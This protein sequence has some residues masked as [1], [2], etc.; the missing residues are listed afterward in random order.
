MNRIL[1][2]IGILLFAFCQNGGATTYVADSCSDTH[3]QAAIDLTSNG[4]TV[5]VPAGSCTWTTRVNITTGITLQ[6]AGVDVTT[7]TNDVPTSERCNDLQLL[8]VNTS[9]N[10]HITGFTITDTGSNYCYDGT[11]DVRG[12]ATGFR[13]NN[14]KFE[15]L[16]YRGI[17][18]S[19][20]TY[21]VIDNCTFNDITNQVIFMRSPAS[22]T[23][24]ALWTTDTTRGGVDQLFI[25][26]CT[27]NNTTP[28]K[29]VFDGDYGTK[30]VF[31]HNTVT[32]SWVL[33]HGHEMSPGALRF[34]VYDNT[35]TV[36]AAQN[37]AAITI[38]GGESLCFNNTIVGDYGNDL[39]V[40][41]TDCPVIYADYCSCTEAGTYPC[42]EKDH[43]CTDN[44]GEPCEGSIG[45]T[46]GVDIAHQSL[47][48]NY[49]WNNTDDGSTLDAVFRV[50]P[51]GC[52]PD[53]ALLFA[54]DV[55]Y[56]NDDDAFDGTSGVGT[57]DQGSRPATCT[58]GTG[59][60][61][62]VAW[63]DGSELDVCESTNTWTDGYYTP[64]T[65]P[66]PLTVDDGLITV[67]DINSGG[68]TISNIGTGNLTIS[69]IGD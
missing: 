6:G 29:A 53:Q 50:Q 69:N 59:S 10:T 37:S 25:E 43:R 44:T 14:I 46:W 19:S 60:T 58:A 3:V 1:L 34:T 40:G 31:R 65:Y 24:D 23:G 66:H 18:I 20:D 49:Q 9:S 52:D 21:G 55:Y 45:R 33:V 57:N 7:I 32:N 12:G 27:F 4:D 62:G 47:A 68:L 22:T 67:S 8:K 63:W 42:A 30:A 38:R 48:P 11:M 2:F 36:L 41:S 61:P 16:N 13:I 28:S 17:W 51:A 15:D 64:Y 26:N 54:E 56:F 39:C 35:F 5:T